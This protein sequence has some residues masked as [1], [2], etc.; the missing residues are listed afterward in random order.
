MSGISEGSEGKREKYGGSK[1]CAGGETAH[2]KPC[3]K[4]VGEDFPYDNVACPHCA[5]VDAYEPHACERGDE[6]PVGSQ[7][8]CREVGIA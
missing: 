1:A 7:T 5:D 3:V 6:L 4:S 8:E 2:P